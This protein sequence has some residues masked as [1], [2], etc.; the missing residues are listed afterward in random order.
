[1]ENLLEVESEDLVTEWKRGVKEKQNQR[2]STK[3]RLFLSASS[4]KNPNEKARDC[5][6]PTCT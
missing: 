2:K 1:M 5:S 3:P 4:R 6:F